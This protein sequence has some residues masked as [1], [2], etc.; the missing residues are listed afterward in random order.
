MTDHWLHGFNLQRRGMAR[1]RPLRDARDLSV[2]RSAP[3]GVQGSCCR[4]DRRSVMIRSRTRVVKRHLD[5]D[6]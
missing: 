3:R 6:W 5:G 4:E 2:A 1:G